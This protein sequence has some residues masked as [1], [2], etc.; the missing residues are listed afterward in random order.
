MLVMDVA[1][2]M[3][4]VMVAVIMMVVIVVVVMIVAMMVRAPPSRRRLA[5]CSARM[6]PPPLVQTSRAPNAAIRRVAGDL[7]RLFRPAHGLG[8]GVEQPGADPDDQR[9]RP[10]PASAPRRTTARCRAARSPRWR[11]DR[12]R[13][14]PCRGRGRRRGRCRRQRKSPSSV[15]TARAVG[16]RGAD[17]RRH[18]AIEFRLLGQ[19]PA[20]DA[21]DLRLGGAAAAP[22]NG[23]CA[24]SA[25]TAPSST[26][27]AATAAAQCA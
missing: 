20:D 27:T 11:P 17:G 22:P 24:I 5:R 18:L 10:A 26:M 4:V 9:P 1:G 7:D 25:C 2:V 16:L 12:T 19:Q 14:P 15:Q 8:G 3:I 21:A 13:S 6:K 23:F